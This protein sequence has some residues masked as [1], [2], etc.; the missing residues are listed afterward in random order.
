MRRRA[1]EIPG[2]DHGGLP[3]PQASVVGNVLVSG[4]ISPTDPATGAKPDDIESQVGLVFD[5]LERI[6]SAAGGTTDDIVKVTVFARDRGIRPHVDARWTAMFPDP[7][8]RPA[9]H[10]LVAD[11]AG[12][13]QIQLEVIA[14]LGDN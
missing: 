1:I 12:N 7:A 9:R 13:M 3:I 4:G 2:L 11:L 5:N 10:T 6:M 8:S 14:I